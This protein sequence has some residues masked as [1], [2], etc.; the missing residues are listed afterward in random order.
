MTMELIHKASEEGR[1]DE[2]LRLLLDAF[3]RADSGSDEQHLYYTTMGQWLTL[4]GTG[5]A[6]ARE[7][8]V[9]VRDEQ[10]ARLLAGELAFGADQ[11][12]Q[13]SRFAIVLT[14]NDALDDSR[15]SYDTFNKLL[16]SAPETA[17]RHAS[18]VVPAMVKV[19]DYTLA[20]KY[21]GDPLA[22]LERLNQLAN[23]F[24][25]YPPRG[26]APRLWAELQTFVSSV[27]LLM[28]VHRGLGREAEAQASQTAALAGIQQEQLRTLAQRELA[29]PG[30]MMREIVD[31]MERTKA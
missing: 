8:M 15:S 25:L 16:V 23:E 26:E 18:S 10:L 3:D 9:R 4:L 22:E 19:G 2:A 29:E 24:P 7:A 21:L 14:M 5:N 31:Y 1:H 6:P 20:E 12:R 17:R 13:R 11:V 28:A 30:L 27:L